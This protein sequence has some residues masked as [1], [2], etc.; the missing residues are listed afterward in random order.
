MTEQDRFA[1]ALPILLAHEGGF[2]DDPHD[3]GGA[4]SLG[5]TGATLACW[6]GRPVTAEDVRALTVEEAGAIYRARY[7]KAA[8][9]DRLP[10]GVDLMVFDCS[11]NQGV[12]RARRFLQEAARVLVDGHVG[13][14]TLAAVAKVPARELVE[15]IRA[16]RLAHYKSLGGFPRYG[17]G[18][19]RRLAETAATAKEWAA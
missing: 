17:K 3:P 5:V 14:V 6:R 8:A 10:A 13:P 16:L 4:T 1:R 9:C 19:T 11:V 15:R 2:V 12:D 18:W 7:W